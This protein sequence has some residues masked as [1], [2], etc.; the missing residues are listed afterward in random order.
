M[1]VNLLGVYPMMISDGRHA[2]H[3]KLS[4]TGARSKSRKLCFQRPWHMIISQEPVYEAD[5][6][7]DQN[8]Y[9][10]EDDPPHCS[11]FVVMVGV[12]AV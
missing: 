1:R 6:A 10:A 7:D 2:L 9:D 3:G 12:M 5:D 4:Q 11:R 8:D